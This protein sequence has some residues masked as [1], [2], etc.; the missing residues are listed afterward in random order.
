MGA[1]G[2]AVFGVRHGVRPFPSALHLDLSIVS[3]AVRRQVCKAV[4]WCVKCIKTS[5]YQTC[6]QLLDCRPQLVDTRMWPGRCA[7][8]ALRPEA[9]LSEPSE[10]GTGGY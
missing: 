5:R 8:A 10:K 7:V 9:R 1:R 3:P 6:M 4:P 2:C